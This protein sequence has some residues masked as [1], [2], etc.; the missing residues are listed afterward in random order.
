MVCNLRR[1]PGI[2]FILCFSLVGGLLQRHYRGM[3][4]LSLA[5]HSCKWLYYSSPRR[6]DQRGAPESEVINLGG[7]FADGD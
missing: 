3:M 2:L 6:D 7:R 1:R 4:E 5:P